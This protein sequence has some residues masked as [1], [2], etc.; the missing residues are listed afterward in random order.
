MAVVERNESRRSLQL[1]YNNRCNAYAHVPIIRRNNVHKKNI[2]ERTANGRNSAGIALR[3]S[4][5]CAKTDMTAVDFRIE[6]T[7]MT[8]RTVD[9]R[10]KTVK[11]KKKKFDDTETIPPYS[12]SDGTRSRTHAR[13]LNA[14]DCVCVQLNDINIII[15]YIHCSVRAVCRAAVCDRAAVRLERDCCGRGRLR[16]F[17][18]LLLLLLPPSSSRW[19]PSSRSPNFPHRAGHTPLAG[20]GRDGAAH[21]R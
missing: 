16:L 19:P 1:F 15:L 11:K 5:G 17:L 9:M 6:W 14:C 13:K 12:C 18:V 20:R 2:D 4:R 8:R 7:A 10:G 3:N 21:R